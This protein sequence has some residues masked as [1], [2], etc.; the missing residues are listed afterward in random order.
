MRTKTHESI[1]GQTRRNGKQPAA[2][3]MPVPLLSQFTLRGP[4][5]VGSLATR[6]SRHRQ[7]FDH[8]AATM[9]LRQAGDHHG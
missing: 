2:L 6:W 5:G 7:V 1:L 4:T 3:R 8:D 9:L